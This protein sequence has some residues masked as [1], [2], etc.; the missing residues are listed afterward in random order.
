[1]T[2]VGKLFV[3]HVSEFLNML[4]RARHPVWM[5]INHNSSMPSNDAYLIVLISNILPEACPRL[6]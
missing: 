2:G 3:W 4:A 6:N 1:M 5:I